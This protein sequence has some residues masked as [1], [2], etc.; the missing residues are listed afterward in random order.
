MLNWCNKLNLSNI[1]K[2]KLVSNE[3]GRYIEII[4]LFGEIKTFMPEDTL[5]FEL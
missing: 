2:D 4:N 1:Y 5:K 3:E